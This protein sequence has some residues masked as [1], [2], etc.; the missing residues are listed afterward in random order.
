M[1]DARWLARGWSNLSS[2]R[3]FLNLAVHPFPFGR[4]RATWEIAQQ[5]R[6]KAIR[7]NPFS[8]FEAGAEECRARSGLEVA[9]LAAMRKTEGAT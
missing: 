7:P 9:M 1:G 3:D 5:E 2:F 4:A 8:L 6:G